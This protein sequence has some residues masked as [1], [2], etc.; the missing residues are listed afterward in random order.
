MSGRTD[1]ASLLREWGALLEHDHFVYI[2]GQHGPER[3]G[4]R[5]CDQ[6]R[7]LDPV[8]AAYAHGADYLAAGGNWP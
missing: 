8:N 7:V 2:S 1:T 3:A 5:R 4:G 6:H